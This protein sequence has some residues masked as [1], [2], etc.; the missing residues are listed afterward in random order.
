[1]AKVSDRLIFKNVIVVNAFKRAPF[2]V[3]LI[4]KRI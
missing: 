4:E 2:G 3:S 1:M